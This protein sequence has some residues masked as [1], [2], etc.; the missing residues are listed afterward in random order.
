MFSSTF[1]SQ[2]TAILERLEVK[3]EIAMQATSSI[4]K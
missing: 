1:I 4:K 2:V 3:F